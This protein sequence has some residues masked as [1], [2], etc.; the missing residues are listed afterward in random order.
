MS[1][2]RTY[3]I[4]NPDSSSVNIELAQ[5]GGA[6][7]S[8]IVTAAT[9]QVG[10]ATTVHT[11]GIDLGSGNITGHNLHST[12]IIT[13]TDF[14]GQITVA[15]G[16][17]ISGST[18][19]IIAST[20]NIERLR[21]TS[22]GRIGIGIS[23]PEANLDVF[24]TDSATAGTHGFQMGAFGIRTNDTGGYNHWYIER[25]Y[26]GWQSAPLV[27]LKGNG[28][29]AIGTASLVSSDTF[30]VCGT[31]RL[32]AGIDYGST[33]VFNVAPGTV[34]WDTPGSPGGRLN[35][36]NNGDWRLNNNSHP[37]YSSIG[38]N[39]NDIYGAT[40]SSNNMGSWVF[41][42]TTEH[43]SPY[44][45]KAYKISA[46]DSN[47][48]TFVYQVWFNGDANYDYGGLYEIRINNWSESTRFTSVAVT[49]INGDSDG[50]RIYAYNNAD[51][52]WITTN[53][54]WGSL[55]IRKFGYDDNRRSRGASLC[56]VDN[57]AALAQGDVNGL[58]GS[59]PGGY[60]EVHA[61]DS[62]GGG[63]DIENNHRFG[64]GGN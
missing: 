7:V 55:Y 21:I 22:A 59:I 49:C 26:G 27:T 2:L 61:S 40:N 37:V 64:T 10:S 48:G 63:Y 1:T 14:S 60:T 29:V 39:M 44:P 54:I 20:N 53:S 16:A 58:S 38:V 56:A 32:G 43:S 30:E 5:G 47:Q 34:K 11:T 50:L 35:A 62:G 51:G 28:Q 12:G 19:T 33:T 52:I 57:G 9:V 36:D 23:N 18:D 25:N 42:G 31:T 46:P 4:Q 41:L 6:V 3:N 8:G 15:A 13:A 45:R 17:T 24:N